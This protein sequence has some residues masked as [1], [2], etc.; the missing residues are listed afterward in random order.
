VV[1]RDPELGGR[2]SGVMRSKPRLHCSAARAPVVPFRRGEMSVKSAGFGK[3]LTVMEHLLR[4]PR[5]AI[6]FAIG[7]YV[8]GRPS[9]STPRN[10]PAE[11]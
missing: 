5:G 6:R 11:A 7:T 8:R 3:P 9:G 4:E 10:R 1:R 2:R